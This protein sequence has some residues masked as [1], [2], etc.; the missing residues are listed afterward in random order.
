MDAVVGRVKRLVAA[1]LHVDE[2]TLLSNTD[3]ANDLG[4]DSLDVIELLIAIESAFHIRIPDEDF[5]E[6]QTFGDV[7]GYV[8]ARV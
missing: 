1:K 3:L 5:A 2:S 6:F 8:A 7:A 4:A